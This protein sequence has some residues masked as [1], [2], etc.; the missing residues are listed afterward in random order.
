MLASGGLTLSILSWILLVGDWAE[1]N[2]FLLF[3]HCSFFPLFMW[4]GFGFS[5]VLS[6]MLASGGLT[7]SLLSWIL[8]VGDLAESLVL[9]FD[10]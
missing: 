9:A 5:E 8:L 3:S 6:G 10:F 7:L 4:S 2:S 1:P